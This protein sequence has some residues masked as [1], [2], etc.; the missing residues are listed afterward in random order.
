MKHIIE[1]FVP[2][3]GK[4]CITNALK[5]IFYYY[6]HPLSEEMIFG[7]ASGLAFTYINLANSPMVSGRSKLFEFE[8][9]LAERLNISIKCKQPKNY[10]IA[11]T[12]TKKMIDHD[13]PV[14]IYADMP[15]MK[16]L[17]LNENSHFGGHAVVIFGYD[18]EDQVFYVSDRDNDNHPIRT[19][20]GDIAEDYHL[21]SYAQMSEARNSKFRPFPANNKC[22]ELDFSNY[23]EIKSE[24]IICAIADT[25]ES[26]LNPPANLT[27]INGITKFAKE[28][29]KWNKFDH[30]KLKTAGITN[31]FQINKDGGTGGGIFRNMYGHFLIEADSILSSMCFGEIGASYISLS[32]QWDLLANSMWRLGETGDRELLKSMSEQILDLYEKEKALLMRLQSSV[33]ETGRCDYAYY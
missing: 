24:T 21:V 29:V 26:M 16:Y 28:V 2:L 20:K 33:Q 11:F 19:P 10:D 7:V 5:Q 30:E 4:H 1:T 31:Y 14:F 22:L 18:D 15:F 3:G 32:E 8:R 9:K 12:K 13:C 23:Q 17:G 6:D 25:C 27:G